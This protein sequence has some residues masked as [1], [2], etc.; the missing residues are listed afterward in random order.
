MV[1]TRKHLISLAVLAG[2]AMLTPPAPAQQSG[3]ITGVVTDPTGSPIPGV[4]V[5]ATRA[6][7]GDRRTVTTNASG[8]YVLSPLAVGDYKLEVRR[9]GFKAVTRTGLRIDVNAA[10]TVDLRLEVGSI[11]ERIT[12]EAT[13]AT[14]ETESQ[15]IGNSRYQV[16]LKNLPIIVREVQALVGQTAGVPYG[17]TDTIGGNVQQGGRSAMQVM[18]DGAQLNPFQT[19]S[20]PS[21]DGIGRRADLTLPSVDSIAEVRWVT[22][23]GSAEF[24]QPTQVIVASKSGSNELHGSLFESYR[25][26]GMGARRWEAPNRES[27]VRH[28]FGGVVGG[29]IRKDK[30]FFFGGVDEF[31]HSSGAVLNARY[32]TAAERGGDLSGLL[33]RTDARGVPA[34]IRLNDPLSGQV[35]PNNLIP[36]SRLSPVATELLK[37]IPNA[38]APARLTDFNAIFFKPQF[39]NSDKFDARFDYNISA[40]DRFFARTTIAHLDQAS[41]FSGAVPGAYGYSTK[42]QW[43]H[44]VASNWTRPPTR[45]APASP[46]AKAD[47]APMPSPAPQA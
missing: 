29:P 20:W 7:T 35:F 32:P 36:A 30:M 27:F 21:I 42:N 1:M 43:T 40:R 25:S 47:P 46:P 38:S 26:G 14:I 17:S 23:G 4:A 33:Q 11:S 34:P 10:L 39:D 45:T 22:N 9:E 3:R 37:L 15:A 8:V 24:S 5:E 19:T 18:A 44:A 16:Q 31:R 12:V 6:G 13:A 28:Q 41:R 2:V